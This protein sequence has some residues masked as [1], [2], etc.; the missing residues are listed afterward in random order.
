MYFTPSSLAAIPFVDSHSAQQ[1]G[2]SNRISA[3][4]INLSKPCRDVNVKISTDKIDFKKLD[5]N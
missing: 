2:A 4:V 1:I 3:V 5:F